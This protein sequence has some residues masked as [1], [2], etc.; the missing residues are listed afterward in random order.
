MVAAADAL[1][2][3]RAFTLEEADWRVFH[4]VLGRPAAEAP[5]LRELLSTPT[6]LDEDAVGA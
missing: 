3:R 6:M 1:A 4:G 5:G 2:D